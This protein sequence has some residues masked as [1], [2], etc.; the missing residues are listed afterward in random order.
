MQE[1]EE[2]FSRQ[3]IEAAPNQ[4]AAP[5]QR[6]TLNQGASRRVIR[7]AVSPRWR[8]AEA[9]GGHDYAATTALEDRYNGAIGA[10]STRNGVSRP[11]QNGAHAHHNGEVNGDT[12]YQNGDVAR[13]NGDAKYRNGVQSYQNG[14]SRCQNEE[15]RYDIGVALKHQHRT[16]E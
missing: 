8:A 15:F 13:Q 16:S 12:R 3:L 7:A 4:G 5:T 2:Y 11:Y 1:V 6:S 14:D 10:A 9:A